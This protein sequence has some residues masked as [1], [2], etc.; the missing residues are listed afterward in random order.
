MSHGAGEEIGRSD[1]FCSILLSSYQ[2]KFIL[3]QN[4]SFEFI[5]AFSFNCTKFLAQKLIKGLL[6]I[7]SHISEIQ[8]IVIKCHKEKRSKIVPKSDW[9]TPGVD[10]IKKFTHNIGPWKCFRFWAI[11]LKIQCPRI[12][13]KLPTQKIIAGL[14]HYD[15]ILNFF[16]ASL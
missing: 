16:L 12:F 11:L 13:Y 3:N 7:K 5:F 4:L 10:A 9:I 2:P 1:I 14:L 8:N 6:F 15:Y